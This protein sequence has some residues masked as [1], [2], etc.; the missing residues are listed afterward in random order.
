LR[1][2]PGPRAWWS[3]DGHA[4][5]TAQFAKARNGQLNAMGDV[6]DGFLAVGWSEKCTAGV[7]ASADGQSWTC[8][9]GG[10]APELSDVAVGGS[11]K[12]QVILGDLN[13]AASEDADPIWVSYAWYRPLP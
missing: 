11:D 6:G 1:F 9:S 10:P 5:A 13:L 8:S 2:C 7:W 3:D 4:W 12:V